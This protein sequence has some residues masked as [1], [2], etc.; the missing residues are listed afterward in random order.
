MKVSMKIGI[1]LIRKDNIKDELLNT[2]G[3]LIIS[4][5]FEADFNFNTSFINMSINIKL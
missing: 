5:K 1:I 3:S 4:V 2:R